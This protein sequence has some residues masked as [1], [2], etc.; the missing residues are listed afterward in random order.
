MTT[1][2]LNAWRNSNASSRDAHA[3]LGVVAVHV[4]DRRLDH[5]GDVGGVD[6]RTRRRRR[7]READLVVDDDVDRAAGAV[8]A[9]L[10][11]VQRLGDDAL[12]G[13]RRV[14]VHEHRQHGEARAP[15]SSR[16]CLART[17]PSTTGSTASRCD[18]L[19]A[20]DTFDRL[21]VGRGEGA[22]GAEVVL[23]VAGAVRRRR[24]DVALELAED[25]AVGLADDVGEHVEAAAVRPCRCTTS[26]SPS[27]RGL[28]RG[29]RRAAG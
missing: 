20:S 10:L 8:A 18:G 16:S 1:S 9:Q 2:L 19:A 4:E 13:E 6:A 21:A 29:S 24:V 5:P 23:H 11:Q 27:S 26:S 25:L 28:G 12:A 17:M 15:R 3:G 14:A 7:G 22:L